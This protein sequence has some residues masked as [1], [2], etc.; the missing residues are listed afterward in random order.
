MKWLSMM[1]EEAGSAKISRAQ[2]RLRVPE[3]T[4]LLY[5]RIGR[6]PEPRITSEIMGQTLLRA[7][8][9]SRLL[10]WARKLHN[11]SKNQSTQS[12]LRFPMAP[13]QGSSPRMTRDENPPS[14]IRCWLS[15]TAQLSSLT[16]CSIL[17]PLPTQGRQGNKLHACRRW[18]NNHEKRWLE[19]GI[20]LRNII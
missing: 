18:G 19:K 1:K 13:C 10:K 9:H 14:Q 17:L 5:L 16:P 4:H 20:I 11:L 7:Q 2:K 3:Q 15:D 12:E 8:Q 6:K